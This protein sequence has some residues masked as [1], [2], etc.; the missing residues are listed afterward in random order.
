[1][2]KVQ[3]KVYL[4]DSDDFKIVTKET[5]TSKQKQE[6][7]SKFDIVPVNDFITEANRK[8]FGHVC[9]KCNNKKFCKLY[10]GKIILK[11][12]EFRR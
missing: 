7:L 5:E 6:Y 11:C 4:E 9:Y 8:K 12:D 1:M 2:A 3:Q 10:S